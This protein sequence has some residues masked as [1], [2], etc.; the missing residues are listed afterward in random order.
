MPARSHRLS[1]IT[2]TLKS[3][4]MCSDRISSDNQQSD[5]TSKNHFYL[6]KST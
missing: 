4:T 2:R 1:I 6:S 5:R 3:L